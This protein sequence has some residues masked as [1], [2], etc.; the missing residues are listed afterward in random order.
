MKAV[1][2]ISLGLLWLLLD[3]ISKQQFADLTPGTRVA[4]GVL[5]LMDLRLVHNTGA[6]WGMFSGSTFLLGVFSVVTCALVF[7]YFLVDLDRVGALETCGLALVVGGGIGNALDRFLQGYV[8]D[9]IEV[10]FMSFPVFNVADIGVTCGIV[11]FVLGLLAGRARDARGRDPE[12]AT[13]LAHTADSGEE[14][15]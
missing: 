1:G 14:A 8:I 3:V 5:G 7:V 12:D 6:A 15:R 10:T 4:A 2:F 11:L 13:G 9:F